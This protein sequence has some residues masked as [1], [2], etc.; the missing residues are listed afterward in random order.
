MTRPKASSCYRRDLLAAFLTSLP[1]RCRARD[2][3][4]PPS[5]PPATACAGV[6]ADLRSDV[7]SFP[8][9]TPNSISACSAPGGPANRLRP[10]GSASSAGCRLTDRP[11]PDDGLPASPSPATGRRTRCIFM[12]HQPWDPGPR[13]LRDHLSGETTVTRAVGRRLARSRSR[14]PRPAP[15]DPAGRGLPPWRPARPRRRRS[16]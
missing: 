6:A 5:A 13:L 3:R 15:M 12:S 16:P 11:E 1:R 10:T 7:D 8:A 14:P 9:T 4:A 2:R